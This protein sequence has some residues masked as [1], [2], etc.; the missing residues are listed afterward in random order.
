M[1]AALHVRHDLISKTPQQ[2]SVLAEIA[3]L[4]D[5]YQCVGILQI[6][7]QRSF[8]QIGQL[9]S[10]HV[11]DTELNDTLNVLLPSL[12]LARASVFANATG[13]FVVKTK[14]SKDLEMSFEIFE[15][16]HER[17]IGMS[18]LSNLDH[19]HQY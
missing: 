6:F 1:I 19:Q 4:S 18:C 9:G 17:F 12:I 11:E 5:Y 2:S 3:L 13:C 7:T 8:S 15:P 16:I 14:G 10:L